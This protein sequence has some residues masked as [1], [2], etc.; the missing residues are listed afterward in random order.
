MSTSRADALNASVSAVQGFV[1]TSS[2]CQGL[3]HLEEVCPVFQALHLQR[4]M[5]SYV[6]SDDW[7]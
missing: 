6:G 1:R 2:G 5:R 4:C 3:E 7:T